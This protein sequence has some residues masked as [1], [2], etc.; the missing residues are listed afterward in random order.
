MG[1]NAYFVTRNRSPHSFITDT[2]SACHMELTLPPPELSYEGSGTNHTFTASLDVCSSCHSNRL[3]PAAFKQSHE[4]QLEEL[5]DALGA[6]L[7]AQL[8]AQI[9][10]KDYTPHQYN[11]N[12]YELKS[13]AVVITK[14]N[15]TSASPTESHGQ[16]EF[17]LQLNQ[18]VN[19]TYTPTGETAHTLTLSTLTVQLGDFTTDG[20][21]QIISTNSVLVKAGWN[22]F[23]VESDASDGIHNPSWV[24]D[25][26][27]NTIQALFPISTIPKE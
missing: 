25:I 20:K 26:L 4:T 17:V 13:G 27:E 6:Y 1:E 9:T 11:G 14:D 23:L 12:S 2:C 5:A 22:Y 3:D 18:P 7:L 21:T 15:I 19:V 24:N 16:Q 10:V 8:P